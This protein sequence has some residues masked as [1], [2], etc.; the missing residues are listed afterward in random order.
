MNSLLTFTDVGEAQT[1]LLLAEVVVVDE[2]SQSEFT[3]FPLFSGCSNFTTLLVAIV[4]VFVFVVVDDTC[5]LTLLR[6]DLR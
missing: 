5:V 4:V 3:D 1:G 2:G 6:Q